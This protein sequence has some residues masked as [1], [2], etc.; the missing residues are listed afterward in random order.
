MHQW[1]LSFYPRSWV[2]QSNLG[3]WFSARALAFLLE[4]LPNF[5][6]WKN[7]GILTFPSILENLG[8]YSKA[9]YA[10]EDVLVNLFKSYCLPVITYAYKSLPPGKSDVNSLNKLITMTFQKNFHPYDTD[11]I[12]ASR[13]NF[14]LADIAAIVSVHHKHFLNR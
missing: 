13:L 11:I 5:V 10:S 4:Y 3:S 14:S 6:T 1:C 9:F 7:L 2:F 12:Y 8:I